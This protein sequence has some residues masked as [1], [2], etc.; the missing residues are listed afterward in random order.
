MPRC[1]ILTGPAR[2]AAL[3]G[4]SAAI[5]LLGVVANSASVASLAF[6]AIASILGWCPC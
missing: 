4:P 1:R 3:G 5:T 2:T 6:I